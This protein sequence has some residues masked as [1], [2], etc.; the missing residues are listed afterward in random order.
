LFEEDER[1]ADGQPTEA[2]ILHRSGG[3]SIRVTPRRDDVEIEVFFH[4]DWDDEHGLDLSILD[5][6]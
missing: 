5:D 1:G 6:A 4:V 2:A 3:G